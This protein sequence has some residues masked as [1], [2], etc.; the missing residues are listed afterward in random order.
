M[1]SGDAHHL[2]HPVARDQDPRCEQITA[3]CAAVPLVR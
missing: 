2:A 3:W 1:S